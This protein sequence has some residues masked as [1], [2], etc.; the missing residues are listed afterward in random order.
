MSSVSSA[1]PSVVAIEDLVRQ[2]DVHI[3]HVGSVVIAKLTKNS[4]PDI[5]LLFKQLHL[6]AKQHTNQVTLLTLVPQLDTV[7]RIGDDV[8][9]RAGELIKELNPI[10]IGSATV[11]LGKGLGPSMI[12]MF[13]TGF[14]MISKTPFPQRTFSTL[15]E[16]ITWIQGLPRQHPEARSVTRSAVVKHFEIEE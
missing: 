8:R 14:N 3:A 4:V 1:L 11:V 9:R 5:E 10:C 12:R 6:T 7:T 15:A 16:G 2:P 13:M